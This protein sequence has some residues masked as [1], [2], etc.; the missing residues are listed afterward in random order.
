DGIRDPLVTG[1]QTCALPISFMEPRCGHS[2]GEVRVHNDTRAAES[3]RA[4]NAVAYT[5]GRDVVFGAG[6]F[7]PHSHEG[8]KL[9]AHEL[10]H[11]EIGRASCRERREGW[12]VGVG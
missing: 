4:V 8:R 12:G 7:A 11:V 3:A 5:V 6:Q 2:F 9:I 1:V 10:T